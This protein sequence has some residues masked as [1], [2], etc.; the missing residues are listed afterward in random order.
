MRKNFF[1][2]LNKVQ[3][4]KHYSRKMTEIPTSDCKINPENFKEKS[5]K[6]IWQTP[7]KN[8]LLMAKPNELSEQ[9]IAKIGKYLVEKYDVNL[10][11]EQPSVKV[12]FEESLPHYVISSEEDLSKV[13]L[14]IAAGGDGTV[15]YINSLFQKIPIPPM[16]C[17]SKG[18]FL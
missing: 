16:L 8:I 10:I 5:T 17:F 9:A 18:G 3:K 1:N 11:F 2:H 7:P 4:L 6:L 13:D 12:H 15:L 14:I